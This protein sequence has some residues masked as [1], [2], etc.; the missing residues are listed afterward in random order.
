MRSATRAVAIG[1]VVLTAAGTSSA[2]AQATQE[3]PEQVVGQFLAAFRDTNWLDAAAL[4]HP[5]ALAQFHDLFRF[6]MTREKGLAALLGTARMQVIG[7]VG[8]GADTV[9]VL[10]RLTL[11]LDGIQA[12]RLEVISFARYGRTWRTLLKADCS[13]MGAVLRRLCTSG[14]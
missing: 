13:A 1:L 3:A 5:S 9:H 4:M 7:H 8:E 14:S 2:L 6:G 10:T 12:S 11:N